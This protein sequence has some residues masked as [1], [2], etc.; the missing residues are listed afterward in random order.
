MTAARR[1]PGV[2]VDDR[3]Q[4]QLADRFGHLP[5]L[6][7][8]PNDES[9][10]EAAERQARQ[11][12]ARARLFEDRVPPMY[13]E[14]RL[15][16]LLPQQDPDGVVSGFLDSGCSALV[17]VGPSR[18]GKTHAAY[19]IGWAARARRQTVYATSAPTLERLLWTSKHDLADRAAERQTAVD[20]LLTADGLIL[21]D[22]GRERNDR[23]GTWT[24]WLYEIVDTRVTHG[25]WTV[26]TR[27]ASRVDGPLE[28]SERAALTALVETYTTPIARRLIDT[29][30]FAF[31][32]GDTLVD[33]AVWGDPFRRGR[34]G[35]S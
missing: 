34:R 13:A 3:L 32:D 25:R 5:P 22:L 8:P 12:R 4:R 20:A 33:E 19:A 1:V 31:V 6:P 9:D 28:N 29:G 35:D 11:D 18:K 10:D 7:S 16:R 27:N 21:D 14:A 23:W 17:L 26:I 30:V 15:E 2:Q 24:Q